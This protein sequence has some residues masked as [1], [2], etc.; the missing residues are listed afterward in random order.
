MKKIIAVA[1]LIL[2][3]TMFVQAQTAEDIINN[4]IKA[5]GGN[6]MANVTSLVTTMTIQTQGMEMTVVSYQ[7]RPNKFKSVTTIPGMG[8]MINA[9]DGEVAW[10]VNPFAGMAEPTV[11]PEE[12]AKDVID[13]ADMDGKIFGYHKSEKKGEYAGVEEI[14]GDKFHAVT[15][16]MTEGGDPATFYF[17][18]ESG[19]LLMINATREMQGQVIE[20]QVNFSDYRKDGLGILTA[21]A[22][23]QSMA[24]QQVIM[25]VDSIEYNKAIDDAIFSMEK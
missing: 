18:V 2:M 3:V 12:M 19:L 25:T 20:I 24:G 14:G 22:I 5:V 11:L 10:A 6:K 13:Q 15:M 1:I 4:H 23:E 17:E 16:P 7:K 8:E 9:Y 21:H